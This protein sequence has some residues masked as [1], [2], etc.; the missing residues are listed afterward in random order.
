[1]YVTADYLARQPG[2][3]TLLEGPPLLAVGILSPNDTQDE[4]D[5]KVQ[6]YLASGVEL[7]WVVNPR[8]FTVTVYRRD[9]SVQAFDARSELTAEPHL[10]GFR[11]P[12]AALFRRGL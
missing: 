1:A 12:V 3:S 11:V 8:L 4:I 2:G 7:V 9:G 6:D 10:S 5:A